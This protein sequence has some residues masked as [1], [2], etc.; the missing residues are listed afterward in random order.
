MPLRN[1]DPHKFHSIASLCGKFNCI[2]DRTAYQC[3][4][5]HV[6]QNWL[7]FFVQ[8]QKKKKQEKK[9]EKEAIGSRNHQFIQ[10]H[11][12]IW[13]NNKKIIRLDWFLYVLCMWVWCMS[14]SM[15]MCVMCM[16]FVVVVV[17]QRIKIVQSVEF[18]LLFLFV[19]LGQMG[20]HSTIYTT[21]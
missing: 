17:L 10:N 20:W 4:S 19:F 6:I 3:N 2:S 5:C 18:Q 9:N 8:N 13:V 11:Q 15:H 7:H 12:R 21:R 14:L 16:V 1:F